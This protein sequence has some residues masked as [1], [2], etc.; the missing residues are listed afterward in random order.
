MPTKKQLIYNLLITLVSCFASG[1]IGLFCYFLLDIKVV[2][3]Y[4]FWAYSI[5]ILLNL[6]FSNFHKNLDVTFF[7][8]AVLIFSGC[9]TIAMFS[10]GIQ[11]PMLF[12]LPS[13]I[14][15]GYIMRRSYGRWT[16]VFMAVAI[17]VMYF[18]VNCS[19]YIS[20]YVPAHSKDEFSLIAILISI[21]M[22]GGI[23]GDFMASS[24]YQVYKA[25]Q[26][27]ESQNREKEILL[28][29]IHHRVKNNLQIVMSLLRL[30]TYN[31]EEGKTKTI[32]DESRNRIASMAL[33]HEMLYKGDDL[34]NIGY[35][36]YI[37]RLVES[38]DESLNFEQIPIEYDIKVPEIKLKLD[39]A[40]PLGLLINEILTNT[41]KY[42]LSQ[43]T[44]AQIYIELK[45]TEPNKYHLAI[46]DNGSGFSQNKTADNSDSLG[47]Q[48]IETLADQLDG[49][50]TRK[51]L[52]GTHYTINFLEANSR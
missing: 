40:I 9:Y 51:N 2:I 49:T 27:I 32:L 38:L 36:V 48:L 42:G 41:F 46:G 39:T 29:E 20:D 3:P 18:L 23:L 7:I 6:G 35:N 8:T 5:L 31:L 22:L 44:G 24:S 30:Q 19:T 12:I 1:L 28:K 15:G 37:E 21:V 14:I 25:K 50:V 47:L 33:T 4:I 26:K 10:G 16:A 17:F 13:I 43:K 52:R 34:A 45:K 11:S